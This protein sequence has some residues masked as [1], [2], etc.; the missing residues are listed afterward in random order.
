MLTRMSQKSMTRELD[1]IAWPWSIWPLHNM[2]TLFQCDHD[3]VTFEW[4]VV[5]QKI[6]VCIFPHKK[7]G[8]T[9]LRSHKTIK[10]K[11]KLKSKNRSIIHQGICFSLNFQSLNYNLQQTG[12]C[13]KCHLFFDTCTFLPKI[14]MLLVLSIPEQY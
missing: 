5:Q 2:Q 12:I 3:V 14:C 4:K 9:R 1:L 13:Y 10:F 6:I 8:N 7:I 11:C